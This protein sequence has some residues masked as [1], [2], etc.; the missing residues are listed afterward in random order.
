MKKVLC[1]GELLLRLSPEPGGKWIHRHTMPVFIGGAELNV[2][3]A[4]ARWQVPVDY[5]TALPD[6]Y[7]SHEILTSVN[8]RGVETG[9]VLFSGSRIGTYYLRQGADLKGAGTIYDR[10]YSS[11]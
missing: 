11:F 10:A 7:L 1:F 5:C 9:N 8:E 3:T 4:L 2:A 6:H